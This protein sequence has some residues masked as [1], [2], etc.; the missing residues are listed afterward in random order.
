MLWDLDISPCDIWSDAQAVPKSWDG[1]SRHM[2]EA[3]QDGKG[4]AAVLTPRGSPLPHW[5]RNQ[6]GRMGRDGWRT[7]Q[8]W[9]VDW[10]WMEWAEESG[11]KAGRST[12]HEHRQQG[13]ARPYVATRP[14]RSSLKSIRLQ[15]AF[16]L[17]FPSKYIL[18]GWFT[19]V[20]GKKW[21]WS[22]LL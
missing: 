10:L 7:A 16:Q 11:W 3:R 4:A 15:A 5:G 19:Q 2:N 18:K 12:W 17:D 9:L 14:S 21:S 6:E 8:V 20:T 22:Y 13:K 1:A